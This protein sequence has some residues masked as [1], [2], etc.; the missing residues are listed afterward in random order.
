MA[1]DNLDHMFI[2]SLS[3][4]NIMSIFLNIIDRKTD[5]FDGE[6]KIA[7]GSDGVGWAEF[8]QNINEHSRIICE[9]GASGKY[10]FAPFREILIPKPPYEKDQLEKAKKAGRVR[11]LS[12]STI[13]DTIF[14]ELLNYILAPHVEQIF[15]THIDLNSFAYRKEK[16]SKMA[17]KLIREYIKMGYVYIIDGDIEKFFDMICHAILK[18]KC[19]KIFNGNPLL[20][21]YLYRFMHVKRIPENSYRD[22]LSSGKGAIRRE[23]GIPQGGVLSGLLANIYLYDFDRYV[24]DELKPKYE[25]QYVRYA[26]DFVLMFK[27]RDNMERC[28]ILLEKYLE[29]EQLVLHPLGQKS[30]LIDVSASGKEAL[31]FLGFCISPKFLRIKNSNIM[32]FLHRVESIVKLFVATDEYQYVSNV[33]KYLLPKVIGLENQMGINGQCEVCGQLLRKR[34]WMGY[35]MVID[36]VRQLRDLDTRIRGMIYHDYHKKTGKYLKK[37]VLLNANPS[38]LSL[39]KTYY[40]Y[41]KQE[42]LVKSKKLSYC[43][44]HRYYDKDQRKIIV[45]QKK[46]P[47]QYD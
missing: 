2:E 28:F 6:T 16:S 17:V 25:F 15:K 4:E 40:H 9:K 30:K 7:K 42:R 1:E 10:C 32:K 41:K 35:F 33:S 43:A 29:K 18:E 39:E 3:Q 19:E 27:H 12:I 23:I 38:L 47:V 20:Q 11:T 26:D 34:N 36:D 22:Y 44:C 14:Q 31:D 13:Q 21:K 8:E 45:D 37:E 5:L 46:L 24:I